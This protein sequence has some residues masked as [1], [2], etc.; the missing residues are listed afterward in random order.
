M[1]WSNETSRIKILLLSG[2]GIFLI[3]PL[4]VFIIINNRNES[5]GVENY[6]TYVKDL[7]PN[8]RSSVNNSIYL[9]VS[10]NLVDG[11][12]M[13][14][15]S[16]SIRKNPIT[17][18]YSEERDVHSGTFIVDLK[19]VRQSY[20]VSYDWSED[21]NNPNTSGYPTIV[22]CLLDEET[23]IYKDFICKDGS[24]SSSLP[25]EKQ[26]PYSDING[27]FKIIYMFKQNN[28]DVIGIT[29]S[30]PNGRKKAIEW[31]KSKNIDPS[32]LIINYLDIRDQLRSFKYAT[33]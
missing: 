29:N 11:E 18:T 15:S 1:M 22:R 19:E 7:P 17:N 21:K 32:G 26:L 8:Y 24:E 14:K 23:I 27:P 33:E 20:L 12:K 9:A 6:N 28:T 10:L 13:I 3:I 5:I 4:A 30:T 31:L 2:V 16:A 25:L